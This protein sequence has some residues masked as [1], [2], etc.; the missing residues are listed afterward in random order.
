MNNLLQE[1]EAYA[2]EH[3]VP[4]IKQAA[5]DI[6]LRE[7]KAKRPLHIL[8]VGTAIGY[9]ALRMAEHLAQDGHITTIELSEERADLADSY[10]ARSP[11]H[12]KITILRGDAADIL[13]TL[14]DSYDFVF[15]D[16]AKGQYERYLDSIEARLTDGAVIAADNVLFRGYVLDE[17]AEVPRR[18]RTIVNRL[19]QFLAM[20]EANEDYTVDIYPE[21]DGIA[22]C[23]YKNNKQNAK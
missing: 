12:D 3:N 14:T 22:V 11:Y 8:E 9:S 10:I 23:K 21:G 6:L 2:Q 1:M 17:N 18:F 4:I 20:L 19:R 7:A 15:I 13:P 5:A 16:A